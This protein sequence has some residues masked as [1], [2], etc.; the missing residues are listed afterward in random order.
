[1]RDPC[2]HELGLDTCRKLL[3]LLRSERAMVL[4]HRQ[5]HLQ[6]ASRTSMGSLVRQPQVARI[7]D[8]PGG[9]WLLQGAALL[10]SW[11]L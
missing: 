7:P 10:A 8:Q 2:L 5:V 4:Q 3:E 1:M 11:S 6:T 9:Q